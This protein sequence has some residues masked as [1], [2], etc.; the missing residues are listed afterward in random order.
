M[1]PRPLALH[2]PNCRGTCAPGDCVADLEAFCGSIRVAHFGAGVKRS[3]GS[4]NGQLSLSGADAEDVLGYLI[5]RGWEL[6]QRFDPRDDGR[7]LT[8]LGGFLAQRLHFACTDWAR[9]RF[10]STRY[11]PIPVF[12]PTANPGVHITE[13]WLDPDYDGDYEDVLDL[14][15]PGL[16]EAVELLRP[17]L[18]DETVT[19]TRAAEQAH[20]KPHQVTRALAQVRAAARQQ[21]LVPDDEERRELADQVAELRRRRMTY[22]QIATELDIR[23]HHAVRA[24]LLDYYPDLVKVR[25]KRPRNAKEPRF[26]AAR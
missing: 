6:A 20:V 1:L 24:L 15:A 3:D 25:A 17:L 23:D 13:T 14:D 9:K 19:I 2:N 7:G 21:G 4:T 26:C 11:G 12:T 5:G 10:G 18:D 8:R 16:R 22:P